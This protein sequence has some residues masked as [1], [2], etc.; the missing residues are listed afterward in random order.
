MAAATTSV[1]SSSGKTAVVVAVGVRLSR[2]FLHN[3]HLETDKQPFYLYVSIL[4]QNDL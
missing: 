1:N 3:L 2:L 4:L